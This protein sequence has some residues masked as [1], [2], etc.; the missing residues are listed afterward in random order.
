[1]AISCEGDYD[2][3]RG[4]GALWDSG[5]T[6]INIE[7]DMECSDDLISGLLTCPHPLCTYAYKLYWPSTHQAV[8]HYAQAVGEKAHIGGGSWVS[9]GAEWADYT[10]IG[11][12]KVEPAV[13]VRPLQREHWALLDMKVTAATGG[14][15]HIHWPEIEHYHK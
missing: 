4:L 7:H 3:W 1:M 5:E 15:W 13:R 10:G 6:I 9:T 2:Y 11:F 12:C 14:R 8:P